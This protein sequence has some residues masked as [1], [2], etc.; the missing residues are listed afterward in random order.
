LAPGYAITTDSVHIEPSVTAQL[1]H[2]TP[3]TDPGCSHAGAYHQ[4]FLGQVFCAAWGKC[5]VWLHAGLFLHPV[6][7]WPGKSEKALEDKLRLNDLGCSLAPGR[8]P[9]I[10]S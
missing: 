10:L 8:Q 3:V 5:S 6:T 4:G 2:Q 7:Q 9:A 1:N